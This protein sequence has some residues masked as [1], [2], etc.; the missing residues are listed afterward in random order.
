ML[1]TAG[2]ERVERHAKFV[3]EATNGLKVPHVVHHAHKA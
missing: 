2:F 1:W 3:M